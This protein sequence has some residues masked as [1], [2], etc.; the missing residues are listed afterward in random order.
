MYTPLTWGGHMD[1][2]GGEDAS[3]LR[4]G[5]DPQGIAC[6][7][8]LVIGLLSRPGQPR[9]R[10]TPSQPRPQPPGRRPQDYPRIKRTLRE[11]AGALGGSQVGATSALEDSSY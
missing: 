11:N 5:T 9:R 4:T 2:D 10:P 7:R 3:Q 1:R 8:N 6:L